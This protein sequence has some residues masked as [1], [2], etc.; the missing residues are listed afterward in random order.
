MLDNTD[1]RILEELSKN[2]RIKMKELGEKVH[3]TGQAASARVLK[4]EDEG[5]IKGYTINIDERKLGYII[6]AFLNIYTQS[7]HHHP[8]LTFLESQQEHVIN[9]FKISGDGC[10]LLECKFHSNEELN[11]FLTELNQHVNYK[12]SIV[13][14]K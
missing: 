3:L 2:G 14:N 9:N 13:I 8:Y 12:L 7:I 6:H 11:D 5:I 1:K 4:L 10:Y